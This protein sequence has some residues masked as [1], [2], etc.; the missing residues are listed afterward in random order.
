MYQGIFRVFHLLERASD[1]Y[2]EIDDIKHGEAVH[3]ENT[4]PGSGHHEHV[5]IGYSN[6]ENYYED[7]QDPVTPAIKSAGQQAIENN[8]QHYEQ[9]NNSRGEGP[10]PCCKPDR[11][12]WIII[13]LVVFLV[14]G[15]V[16]PTVIML[17][18]GNGEDESI[19]KS[20]PHTII[21]ATT[22]ITS[23]TFGGPTT[24]AAPVTQ[25]SG[26]IDYPS[27]INDSIT[28]FINAKAN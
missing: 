14:V 19:H 9:L 3:Y 16:T 20:D 22:A 18:K 27:Y 4:G 17:T 25:T 5:N 2:E 28:H 8:E 13:I 26:K 11:K 15:T 10:T 21:T 7:P 24:T 1:V 12:T 6:E 23:T